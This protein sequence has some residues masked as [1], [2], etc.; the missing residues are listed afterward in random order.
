M[1]D[2]VKVCT[3]RPNF[4][5][6]NQGSTGTPSGR[7]V[8]NIPTDLWYE[9]S[10]TWHSL[11]V[12]A[13]VSR[14]ILFCQY[15]PCELSVKTWVWTINRYRSGISRRSLRWTLYGFDI[16]K[17]SNECNMFEG[18]NNGFVCY[19]I[20]IS[21]HW[22]HDSQFRDY[23]WNW[24]RIFYHV[25][26]ILLP[27]KMEIAEVVLDDGFQNQTELLILSTFAFT[28]FVSKM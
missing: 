12:G 18:R 6:L 5:G 22:L 14:Q 2:G 4:D 27:P 11:V 16:R 20:R 17:A 13:K 21:F 3:S 8:G 23:Q 24:R 7:P 26:A 19:I 25:I 10:W 9:L 28:V 15:L 1:S